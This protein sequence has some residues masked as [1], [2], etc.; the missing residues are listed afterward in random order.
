ME[1]EEGG[2]EGERGTE[3]GTGGAPPPGCNEVPADVGWEL[4]VEPGTG[5]L[6]GPLAGK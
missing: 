3:G 4:P 2:E 1:G 6:A 5:A